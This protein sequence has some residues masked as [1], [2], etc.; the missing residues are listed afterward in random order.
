MTFSRIIVCAISLLTFAGC[1]TTD[2]SLSQSPSVVEKKSPPGHKSVTETPGPQFP[3]MTRVG[4]CRIVYRKGQMCLSG[5]TN[6]RSLVQTRKD[7]S[8]PFAMRLKVKTDGTSIRLYYNAGMIILNWECRPN[9]L[10]FHDLLENRITSFPGKG[11]VEPNKFHD[12]VWEIY[13]DGT[14]LLVNG[15][16]VMRKSGEYDNLNAPVGIG[17]AFGSVLTIKSIAITELQGTLD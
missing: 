14:R 5:P 4:G 10:R 13:A 3:P 7:Y 8:P 6:D 12:I 16:E 2:D 9:M 15:N 1:M 17:P 11:A